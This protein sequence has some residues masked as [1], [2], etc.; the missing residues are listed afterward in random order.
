MKSSDRFSAEGV[1]AT[2]HG[3]EL[4]ILDLSLGGFFVA[5]EM[6]PRRG[7]GVEVELSLGGRPPFKV[8]G[9]VAWIVTPDE[10]AAHGTPKGYGVRIHQIGMADKLAL[11][12][13]LRTSAGA[14]VR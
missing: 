2:H 4:Q 13:F 12:G 3:A 1:R 7:S 10:A 14:P 11:V 9:T 6:P 5:S 8:R